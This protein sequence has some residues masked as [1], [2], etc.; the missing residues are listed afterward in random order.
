ML[1]RLLVGTRLAWCVSLALLAPEM[2]PAPKAAALIVL[3]LALWRPAFALVAVVAVVPAGLLLA[4]VPAGAAE[5]VTWAFLCGWLIGVWRPLAVASVQT[6]FSA[7]SPTPIFTPFLT[8]AALYAACLAASW[9]GLAI[10]A[11]VGV[12]RSALAVFVLLIWGQLSHIAHADEAPVAGA[13][14]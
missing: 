7:P 10:A 11:A 12:Q 2:P 9:T 8:S 5:L 14:G 3:A 1:L 4:S 13:P 6:D